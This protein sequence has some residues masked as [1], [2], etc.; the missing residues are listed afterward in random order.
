M[1]GKLAREAKFA[2]IQFANPSAK[3]CASH[4]IYQVSCQQTVVFVATVKRCHKVEVLSVSRLEQ[5]FDPRGAEIGD[6]R[7]DHCAGF[8]PQQIRS[9]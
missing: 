9:G 7:R 8:C 4:R 6:F 3:D 5:A 1:A 2:G